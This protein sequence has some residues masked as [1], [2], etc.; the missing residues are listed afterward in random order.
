[1]LSEEDQLRLGEHLSI[2]AENIHL[3]TLQSYETEL[4]FEKDLRYLY[5]I[6]QKTISAS[7]SGG[8]KLSRDSFREIF[9]DERNFEQFLLVQCMSAEHHS[10]LVACACYKLEQLQE[11]FA[12]EESRVRVVLILCLQRLPISLQ[13]FLANWIKNDV[14]RI[15]GSGFLGLMMSFL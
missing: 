1:M 15:Q 9:N 4:E 5:F 2:P 14:D 11:E 13:D 7:S 12:A 6:Y 3:R 8:M 10:K